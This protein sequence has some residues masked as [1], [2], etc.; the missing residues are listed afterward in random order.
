MVRYHLRLDKWMTL[1]KDGYFSKYTSNHVE[2][3]LIFM[4]YS[5]VCYSFSAID[6]RKV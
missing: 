4:S 3:N 6:E 5:L 2:K 1:E